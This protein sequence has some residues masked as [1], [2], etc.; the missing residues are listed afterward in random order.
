MNKR[1]FWLSALIAGAVMAF[2][3][4][5]P[6]INF[7]NCFVCLWVWV[8][9]FV[10]VYCYRRFTKENPKL[11]KGQAAGLG[12]MAGVFGALFGAILHAI[13]IQFGMFG[14]NKILE[15]QLSSRP[16]MAPYIQMMTAGGFSIINIGIDL[17]LY[18]GFG[19]L[20]GLVSTLV[21]WKTPKETPAA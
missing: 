17:I 10:A 19:A 4:N 21:F 3:G 8:G 7:F 12:A 13:F 6:I 5:F 2:L 16:E 15:S 9:G 1:G 14:L 18:T 20:S 11:S